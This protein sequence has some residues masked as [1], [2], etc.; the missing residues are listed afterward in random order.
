[1]SEKEVGEGGKGVMSI[2]QLY[3]GKDALGMHEVVARYVGG[4]SANC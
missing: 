2:G 1:M 4:I 3:L